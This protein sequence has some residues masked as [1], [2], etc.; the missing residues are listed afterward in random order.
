MADEDDAAATAEALGPYVE[1]AG[2]VVV[3]VHVIERAG[4]APDR[5]SVEQ[6]ERRADDLLEVVADGLA[7]VELETESLYGTDLQR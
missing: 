6:R 7:D 1:S 5:A 3:G 4:R 2:G